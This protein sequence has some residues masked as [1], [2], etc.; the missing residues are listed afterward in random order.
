MRSVSVAVVVALLV[1]V[2]RT[3]HAGGRGSCG[4]TCSVIVGALAVGVLA[5]YGFGHAAFIYKDLTDDTQSATYAGGELA[6]NAAMGGLMTAGLVMSVREKKVRNSFIYGGLGALH[7]T[8]A[9]HGAVGLYKARDELS[10]I[11]WPSNDVLPYLGAVVYVANTLTWTS[12]LPHQHSRNYGILELS[13]NAPITIGMGYLTYRS[14]ADDP[15][16]KGVALGGLTLLSGAFAIHGLTK[17][18]AP[19]QPKGMDLLRDVIPVVVTDGVNQ[20]P[21]IGIVGSW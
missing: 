7:L 3:A 1:G 2:P 15:G 5:G 17:I 18:I 4:D 6:Y 16:P 14:F 21:G 19:D 8:L 12:L 9:T 11:K 10:P 20:G 13:V